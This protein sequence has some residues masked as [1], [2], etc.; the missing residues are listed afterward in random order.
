MR[1]ELTAVE[2]Q[3]PNGTLP[4]KSQCAILEVKETG[5]WRIHLQGLKAD[6]LTLL[7]DLFTSGGV[8]RIA[9]TTDEGDKTSVVG[10]VSRLSF[11][12][13]NTAMLQGI[14]RFP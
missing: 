4:L 5:E 1:I 6:S 11:G 10:K 7:Q 3:D 14:S 9:L 13:R 8:A 2:L 12:N